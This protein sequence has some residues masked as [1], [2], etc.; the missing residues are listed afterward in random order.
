MRCH[1]ALLMAV[2]ST[3]VGCYNYLP[4]RRSTLTPSTFLALTLTDDGSDELARYLGPGVLVVRGRFLSATERG[5]AI[6]V[7]SVELRRGDILEWKGETVVVP[8]EFVRQ[9]EERQVAHG[10]TVLLAGASLLGMV[11]AYQAFGPGSAG[12]SGGGSGGGPTPH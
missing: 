6:S 10:K 1:A 3:Q 12:G 8:G 2:V 5:L 4:V 11:V 9:V 7:G